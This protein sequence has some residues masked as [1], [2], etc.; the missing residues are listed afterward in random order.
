[1]PLVG[2]GAVIGCIAFCHS[3]APNYDVYGDDPSNYISLSTKDPISWDDA[4]KLGKSRGGKKAHIRDAPGGQD[5]A[6]DVIEG[7]GRN[8]GATE[9]QLPNGR[10]QVRLPG[11]R[12]ATLY[13]SNEGPWTIH[14]GD[15]TKTRFD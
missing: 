1:M 13:P 9:H 12:T 7:L 8:P 6:D 3:A 2:I 11:G 5:A 14:C 10:I 4:K 15:G